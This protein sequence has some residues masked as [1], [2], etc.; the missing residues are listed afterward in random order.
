[1]RRVDSREKTIRIPVR[2]GSDQQI[3]FFYGGGTL[4]VHRLPLDTSLR[5]GTDLPMNG[6]GELWTPE[7]ESEKGPGTR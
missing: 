1:M 6:L 4:V 5:L 3:E 2:V 7:E